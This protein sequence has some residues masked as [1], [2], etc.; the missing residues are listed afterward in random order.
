ML[1]LF[2][3]EAESQVQVLTS[4]LLALERDH[5]AADQLEACMRAAHSLK[6][7][8]RIV[9]LAV[10]VRVAH[11]MEDCFVAAQQGRMVLG[12]EGIDVLL[13]ATDL[14]AGLPA[15]ANRAPGRRRG[16]TTSRRASPRWLASSKVRWRAR[17]PGRPQ[18]LVAESAA[19]ARVAPRQP[20]AG[21]AP[22]PILRTR[23][24]RD[25]RASQPAARPDGRVARRCALDQVLR[26]VAR[27]A[28]AHAQRMCAISS[29]ASRQAI[30]AQALDEHSETAFSRV[31]RAVL[32]CQQFLSQ[33]LVEL[34]TF[35][36][37]SL[38][39]SHR[40]Y[41]EALACRMRPF[42][43]GVQAF[44]RLVRDLAHSLGKQVRL[45]IVGE[46]TQVDRDILTKLEA[47]L[48]H[49]L[50]N[51]V[52]HGIES[53]DERRAK[54]QTRGRHDT[55]RSASQRR[56]APGHRRA[57]MAAAWT[58]RRRARRSSRET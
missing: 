5:A 19:A 56:H 57:T 28:Q 47:P 43:D 22:E 44:P 24:A 11:A 38:N 20:A 40:M 3:M 13:R 23:P 31:Q 12:R 6:G 41:D 58:W 14:M 48:G 34:E 45:E 8:A 50:R 55:S 35:D 9:D 26:R 2:R 1:D 7:A 37:R 54:R 15:S 16:R 25:G 21:P 52:D 46:S 39:L 30:P 18:P 17:R 49:L 33:R 42:A 36:S 10:G 4:G 27:A 29:T 32:E 53:P 51:A